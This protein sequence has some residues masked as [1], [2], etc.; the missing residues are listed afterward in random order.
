M[1]KKLL[2]FANT[3]RAIFGYILFVIVALAVL[4]LIHLY[5]NKPPVIEYVYK[6]QHRPEPDTVVKWLERIKEVKVDPIIIYDTVYYDVSK[7]HLIKTVNANGNE[8]I[9]QTQYCG[10][11]FGKELIYPYTERFQLVAG[12]NKPHF[13]KY[14]DYW[15]W[16][17]IYIGYSTTCGLESETRLLFKPFSLEGS[18]KASFKEVEGKLL[19]HPF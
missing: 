5:D 6:P 15:D 11:S 2:K 16:D 13:T 10:E 19:W 18:I 9:V 8:I 17:K 4:K 14:K 3:I 7:K 1:L 12:K